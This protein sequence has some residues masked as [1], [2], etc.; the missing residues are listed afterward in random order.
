M[1]VY[2]DELYR[3]REGQRQHGTVKPTENQFPGAL[4]PNFSLVAGTQLLN[5]QLQRIKPRIHIFGELNSSKNLFS[6]H[7]DYP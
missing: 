2:R 4:I 1:E 5:D 3:R 6:V 7:R